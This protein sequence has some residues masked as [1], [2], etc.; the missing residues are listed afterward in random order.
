MRIGIVY[1]EDFKKYDFGPGHPLRGIY[2][3]GEL[4]FSLIRNNRIL[5]NKTGID[6]IKPSPASDQ[7][8]LSIHTK[9][10]VG[11]LKRLNREGG[12]IT[13]DTP[14]TVG[15]YD[16][17]RLFAGADIEAATLVMDKTVNKCFVFG[18][19]GHHAGAD[20]GGGFCLIN[21][22]AIMI[23]Y[24]RRE[25]GLKRVLV[26][27]YAVNAGHGTISIFYDDP[28]VLCIDIHQDPLTIYPGTG[29][30]EQ[31]GRGNGQGYTVNISLP[32]YTLDRHILLALNEIVAPIA[33]E[34]KPELIVLAGLN[35][36]HFTLQINQF[37]QTLHG[38][39]EI[40]SFFS[41]LSESL[42]D[43]KL[44]HIGGFSLDSKLLPLGF[45][46]TVSGVLDTQVEL[47][48]PFDMPSNIPDVGS[49]VKES[50][51]NVKKIHRRYWR[52]L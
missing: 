44:I 47:P 28:G 43:G 6:F 41:E 19:M 24:V 10:Y 39:W 25:Y 18:M 37:M 52:Y 26:F 45:L 3:N 11:F 4:A 51:E 35:G 33:N 20:F 40:N 27:D 5:K 32:P 30:P 8:V 16:V 42:C 1:H 14:V 9:E 17:A 13:P 2:M 36:G 50:I 12:S 22:I 31:V 34:Y 23:E 15:M 48:E 46:A 49:E 7:E 29:F 21:D 38:L